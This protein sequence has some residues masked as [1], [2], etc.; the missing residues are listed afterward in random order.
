MAET[1]HG[2][3]VLRETWVDITETARLRRATRCTTSQSTDALLALGRTCVGLG[4]GEENRALFC[5]KCSYIDVFTLFGF[6]DV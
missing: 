3:V 4:N 6:Q 5:S 1:I 2:E